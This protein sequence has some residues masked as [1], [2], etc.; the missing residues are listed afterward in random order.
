MKCSC[1]ALSVLQFISTVPNN[2]SLLGDNMG[3]FRSST[4]QF[5]NSP[6]DRSCLGFNLGSILLPHVPQI[7]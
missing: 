6:H 4:E 5:L 1:V 2:N 3:V 7:C